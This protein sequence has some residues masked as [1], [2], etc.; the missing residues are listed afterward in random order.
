M[1]LVFLAS[2]GPGQ[3]GPEAE[4]ECKAVRTGG[5]CSCCGRG[6]CET[7]AGDARLAGLFWQGSSHLRIQRGN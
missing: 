4:R 6:L 7:G 2:K 1:S 3:I 5:G